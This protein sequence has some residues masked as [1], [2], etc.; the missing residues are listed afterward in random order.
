MSDPRSVAALVLGAGRGERLGF[1]LPKAFVPLAGRTLIEHSIRA[2]AEASCLGR[3]VP[4]L[5]PREFARFEAIGL[6]GIE[7]LDGPVEG[8]MERQD[9]MRA[10]LASLEDEV[11]WV[12]VQDAARC[13]VAPEDIR[14]VVAV[15]RDA[16]AAILAEPV[17][18]TIKLV[19]DGRVEETPLRAGLWAAQTPQVIRRDWLEEAVE[20]AERAGR[21][22][23][24]DAQL[25]EWLGYPVR[26]VRATAPN[27]KITRPEDLLLAEA[28]LEQRRHG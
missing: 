7:A 10:G 28:L 11:E 27:P 21:Q 15:A 20:A 2:L 18:D 14:S 13:L 19:S 16:G 5:A 6:A 24:D 9:S 25:V 22:A 23:T 4:V 17:R 3:I 8:G 12:A 26:V 1:D